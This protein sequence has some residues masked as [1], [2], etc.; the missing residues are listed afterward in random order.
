M[1][2]VEYVELKKKERRKQNIKELREQIS[3]PWVSKKINNHLLKFDGM[4]TKEEV[5]KQIE[6][7]DLLASFFCKDPSK[8]NISE[9][10]VA[11]LLEIDKLPAG[12][13]NSIR[14]NEQGDISPSSIPSNTKSAD[15][16]IDGCYYTQKYTMESGGA[17]DNQYND[18]IDFLVKGSKKHKVG[19]IVDG[20]YWTSKKEILKN[21]FKNNP[22]IVILSMDELV[23]G[24]FN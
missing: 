18:V 20:L 23:K 2:F 21:H 3:E 24:G 14:F 5:I 11:E 9:N 15:F 16:L 6:E 10:L 22:N 8:Q 17:Q 7:N 12:G 13:P 19:A 4:F 1:N